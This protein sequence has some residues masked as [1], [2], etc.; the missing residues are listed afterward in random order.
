MP[1][2]AGKKLNYM[3]P[4]KVRFKYCTNTQLSN[5]N[6]RNIK[7]TVYN[8][9]KKKKQYSCL[10]YHWKGLQDLLDPE[11]FVRVIRAVVE[12]YASKK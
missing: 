12:K 2:Y 8:R 9:A 3:R 7:L 5:L 6:M 11:S 1:V 10:M 4:C